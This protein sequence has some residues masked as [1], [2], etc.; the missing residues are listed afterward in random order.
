MQNNHAKQTI[1]PSFLSP[2]QESK[3]LSSAQ[4][5]L[6]Q[7]QLDRE[8]RPEYRRRIKIML[9]AD[10]GK[11]YS[12]IASAL[13]CSNE[14]ARNW[15]SIL[16]QGRIN[17]WKELPLGRPKKVNQEYLDRLRELV[18][19]NPREFGYG[20]H[21]WT[22][23]WLSKHL[24][25]E[26]SIEISDRHINRLLKEM[27]L[28]TKANFRQTST[29]PTR[30]IEHLDLAIGDLNIEIERDSHYANLF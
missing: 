19:R 8:L 25:K 30:S 12:E 5:K 14:T 23:R 1:L 28:S 11:S 4:R 24:A 2:K 15:I 22:A 17:L 3:L 13:D 21:R 6:L 7:N 10:F 18:S 16:K 27:N 9:M 29:K 20:F 26:F